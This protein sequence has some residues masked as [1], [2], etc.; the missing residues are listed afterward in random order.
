MEAEVVRHAFAS[1]EFVDVPSTSC[2][3]LGWMKGAEV[4]LSVPAAE[5][6]DRLVYRCTLLREGFPV[7]VYSCGGL[8]AGLAAERA[9]GREELEISVSP[10]FSP[11]RRKSERHAQKKGMG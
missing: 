7:S 10:L 1:G 8:L 2:E 9:A 6:G 11:P 3:E 5:K 4:A